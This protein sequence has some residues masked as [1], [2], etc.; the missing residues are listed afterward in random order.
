MGKE[1]KKKYCTN[2][3][4]RILPA[5]A[6]GNKFCPGENKVGGECLLFVW[7]GGWNAEEPENDFFMLDEVIVSFK[8]EEVIKDDAVVAFATAN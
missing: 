3:I 5:D 1:G 4:K 2:K 6:P 8:D 7:I